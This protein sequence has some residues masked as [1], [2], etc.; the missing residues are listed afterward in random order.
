MTT[1]AT[2]LIAGLLCTG[3][4]FAQPVAVAPAGEPAVAPQIVTVPTATTAYPMAATQPAP[5]QP[6]YALVEAPTLPCA[7]AYCPRLAPRADRN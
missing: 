2:L 3:V 4:A 7:P 6:H 5:A 1:Q